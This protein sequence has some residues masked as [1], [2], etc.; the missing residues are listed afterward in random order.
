MSGSDQH[1]KT[2]QSLNRK[3]E[4]LDSLIRK[5][6]S[7][8]PPVLHEERKRPESNL[9]QKNIPVLD[10]PVTAE[11]FLETTAATSGEQKISTER[12]TEIIG[13]MEQKFTGELEKLVNEMKHSLSESLVNELNSHLDET[14]DAE[15][16]ESGSTDTQP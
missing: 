15:H 12:I 11:D 7:A 8:D 9:R 5:A 10:K 1:N 13:A 6:G 3:I 4:E 14:D 16:R 2:D